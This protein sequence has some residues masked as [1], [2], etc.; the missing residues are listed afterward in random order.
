MNFR[1]FLVIC[2]F[3]AISNAQICVAPCK[4]TTLPVVSY[5]PGDNYCSPSLTNEQILVQLYDA[6]NGAH[7]IN[8]ANW[9]SGSYCSWYGIVCDQ[10]G[11]VVTIDLHANN[12]QGNQLPPALG[13]LT[14]LKSLVLNNN[15]ISGQL[16]NN[17]CKLTNL[18]YMI[19]QNNNLG[20]YI[21]ACFSDLI[22]LQEMYLYNN[23][24]IGD[25]P[26]FSNYSTIRELLVQN[27]CL[28]GE[29]PQQYSSTVIIDTN[30]ADNDF[31]GCIPDIY[32]LL[33]SNF[34]GNPNYCTQMYIPCFLTE[35]E[36]GCPSVPR[37]TVTGTFS[38]CPGVT[39]LSELQ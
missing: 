6:F 23:G 22:F 19:L 20:G 28:T 12:L 9:L 4:S 24:L 32:E 31:S 33:N 36:L 34:S 38:Y 37:V 27:N 7:W 16:P 10:N 2:A 5:V 39:C 3:I 21:P 26:N 25:L 29:V 1:L 14:Y 13:C 11:D 8:N 18:Q 35:A 17:F 30:F 15:N